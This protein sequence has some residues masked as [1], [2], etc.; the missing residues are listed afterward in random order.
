MYGC[1][2]VCV[3]CS[4]WWF[5]RVSGEYTNTLVATGGDNHLHWFEKS[6]IPF[7]GDFFK[8]NVK[9][10]GDDVLWS[11]TNHHH[12]ARTTKKKQPIA[13]IRKTLYKDE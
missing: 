5:N 6:E 8:I 9:G 12:N 7:L 10:G 13:T 11:Q 2:C 3:V 4:V 1:V